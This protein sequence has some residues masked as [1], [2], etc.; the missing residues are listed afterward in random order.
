MP[1]SKPQFRPGWPLYAAPGPTNVPDA[2]MHEIARPVE[3]FAAPEFQ[4]TTDACVRGLRDVLGGGAHLFFYAASGHG[5]WEAS[6]VNLFSPGDRILMP[7]SGIFSGFWAGMARG[8]GLVVETLP[9]SWRH[10]ISLD[11]LAAAL[12]RDTTH[13]I[14]AVAVVHNDTASGVTLPAA[15]IGAVLRAANHPA[16]Y[17]LDVVSSAGS[18]PLAIDAWGV[19]AAIGA[20][21]KGLMTLPGVGFTVVSERALASHRAARLPR[22]YFDWTRMQARPFAHSLGTVPANL[23]RGLAAGLDLIAQEGLQATLTRHARLARATR[24]AIAAWGRAGQGVALYCLAPERA[25][26]SVSTILLPPGQT[27]AALRD[28]ARN[29]LNVTF[30]GDLGLMSDRIFRIGHMGAINEAMLLGMLGAAELAMR[31]AGIAHG[32]GLD[33]ALAELA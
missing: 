23:F 3:D 33:A 13:R 26:D 28:Y 24:A 9:A 2:V 25:S 30:G 29:R 16:L 32:P 14:R 18:L 15:E 19:D 6:L 7:E 8:L 5:A 22:A 11:A 17:L 31:E 10:G 20:S 21:Q 12:A 27:A 1:S 4:A